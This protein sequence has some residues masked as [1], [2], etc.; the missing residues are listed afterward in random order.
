MKFDIRREDLDILTSLGGCLMDEI[1]GSVTNTSNCLSIK[2]ALIEGNVRVAFE[3][4]SD[5]IHVEIKEQ[6]SQ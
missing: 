1:E 4:G 5:M 3:T 6:D 2:A